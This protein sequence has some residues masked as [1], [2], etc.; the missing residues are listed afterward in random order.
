MLPFLNEAVHIVMEGVA[1]VEDVDV[2]LRLGYE[3][4]I[5]PLEYLDRVGLDTVLRWMEHLFRELGDVVPTVPAAAQDG[6][7]RLSRPQGGARL[8]PLARQRTGASRGGGRAMKVLVL[9]CGSSSVK[10]S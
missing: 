7:G 6:A 2:A 5:G 8:L 3:F 10:Y 4:K 1:S 9:N